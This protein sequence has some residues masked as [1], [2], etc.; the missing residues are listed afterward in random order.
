M[1]VSSVGNLIGLLSVFALQMPAAIL[2]RAFPMEK[3]LGGFSSVGRASALQAEGQR[4]ESAKLHHFQHQLQVSFDNSL[5]IGYL[6][7]YME[8]SSD[9]VRHAFDIECI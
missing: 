1:R 3:A 9:P 5:S 8:G 6:K 4:F 7:S 2:S